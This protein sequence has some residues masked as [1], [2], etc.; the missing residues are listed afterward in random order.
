MRGHRA[1]P[2]RRRS[3]ERVRSGTFLNDADGH[4]PGRRPRRRGGRSARHPLARRRAAG[5]D[6]RPVVHGDRDPRLGAAG[7]RPSTAR[8]SSATRWRSELFGIDGTAVD[9][10]GSAPTLIRSTP[11]ATCSP[12]RRTPRQPNE[13]AVNRPSDALAARAA[14]DEALTALLLALGGVALLV[15]GIGI[16][17]VH[18]DLGAR[19]ATR[20][21]GATG[22][23]CG[24]PPHPC[25]VRGRGDAARGARRGAAGCCSARSITGGYAAAATGRS[26]SPRVRSRP[27]SASHSW[28][29]GSRVSI[30]PPAPARLDPAEAVRAA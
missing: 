7:A 5:V 25:A 12:R 15:G 17:N 6:R 22:A 13:V 30:P 10:C 16:A 26:P 20:D 3:R 11:C 27:G 24:P 1:Q 28:S 21:R 9:A 29:A 2:A 19:A 23:R 4:V 8:P 18:G 14:T